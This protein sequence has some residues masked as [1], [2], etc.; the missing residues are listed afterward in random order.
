MA[1][2]TWKPIKSVRVG[3]KVICFDPKTMKPSVTTVIH[4]YVKPAQKPVYKIITSSGRSVIA[5]QDHKFRTNQGWQEVREFTKN[6]LVGIYATPVEVSRD[7][8]EKRTIM[9]TTG[10]AGVDERIRSYGL[11]PLMSDSWQVPIIARLMGFM[12][13][14]GTNVSKVDAFDKHMMDEDARLLGFTEHGVDDSG[15][16]IMLA[17]LGASTRMKIPDWMYIVSPHAKQE[18]IAGFLGAGGNIEFI[19]EGI[20]QSVGVTL[21]DMHVRYNN[22]LQM[23]KVIEQEYKKHLAAAKAWE[24]ETVY[25]EAQWRSLVTVEGNSVFVPIGQVMHVRNC[26]ISDITVE[27]ENHSFIGGAGFTVSNSAMGKQAVGI[28][29]SNF[30]NRID[31]MA[32]VLNYPQKPL[33]R[34]KLSKYT[35]GDHLPS[36][37]NA[38]VAIMTHTG[39][40]QEDSVMINKS[41]LDRGLFT[42]TYYKSYRDQCSKNHSTGEE[43]IFTKPDPNTTAHMK[44]Y[45]YSKLGDDGLVPVNT[46]VD[47][48]DVLI[49]KV[50]PH[51]IQG[52]IHPR[53]TSHMMK[54]NDEGH[55]DMNYIGTNA[56]GYKFAKVRIRKYRKPMIGDKCASRMAQKGTIGMVYNHQD[57]PFAKTGIVPD[58]IMNPHAIPSRMTIGQLMECIMG[59]ACCHIGS[60]G[61]ST[62]FND[63]TVEGIASVLEKSGM[64]R[65]GNEI[66]YNG[67]TGEMIQTEIF[68]GP[69][70]YQRL[71]HMVADKQHCLTEDHDVLTS[72]GWKPIAEVTMYDQVATLH[73]DKLVYEHPKAVLSFP[74]FSGKMYHIKNQAVDLNVT[75][76]H[77]MYISTC[78]TRKREWSDYRLVPA[79][80]IVGK[81]VRYK[82]NAVW[83]AP[84]YQFILPASG[85]GYREH[86]RAAKIVDMDAWLT[87]FGIWMAEGWTTTYE[88]NDGYDTKRVQICICKER[89]RDALFPALEKLGYTYN[90]HDDKCTI[91]ECQ[92]Y[93]YMKDLSVGAPQ[94]QLPDWV[95]SL[96][97]NQCRKLI[98]AMQLGDGSFSKT[99]TVYYTSS[100][101][102]A[103]QFMQLCL[104]AGW[105]GNKHLHHAKGNR[106]T[107]KDGRVIES[108]HDLWKVTVVVQRLNPTVNHTHSHKQNIQSEEVYDFT[109]PV[110]CLQVSSEV[111]MVRR[112]GKAVWTGNSRG[113]NGPVVLMTR[114]PAEGRAR[115]GGLRFGEMERDAIVAHGASAFLKERMQ[116]TSDNYRVFICRQCGLICTANPEKKIYKC[117]N[118]KNSADIT[119]VRIPYS[120]K[121]LIQELMTMSVAPRMIV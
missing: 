107:L 24:W 80:E 60:L 62:P 98:Y 82:K 35:H 65:Y 85:E 92:L 55:V 96:S 78:H 56:D 17:A 13:V 67:R 14:Q 36:G 26:M 54:A 49:G 72:D 2:G 100:E 114:Q 38:I 90:L 12:K 121:L 86:P 61:D 68:I 50:M 103:D 7:V 11:L 28:Y 115:N 20:F 58:L 41:A 111:F 46:H 39:F 76:N 53:D 27:S 25:T 112:N 40:N 48:N 71:K 19:D 22:K 23:G 45:N 94:K 42:S 31:T 104:H 99:S 81:E 119:Q 120:M 37:I 64:E 73:G 57:M 88:K 15:L 89:V 52:A 5:T 106:A 93:A 117:T 51:K 118:C 97:Q 30:N 33:V 83:D 109:G 6:T 105:S 8:A 47:G 110:Y 9:E 77:R 66:L 63:C 113:S 32:H 91:N 79:E 70:Y 10:V 16:H 102:L 101:K 95:W 4:Q 74:D 87:F 59:K 44:P 84:D 1:D 18:Y 43:E 21:D 34:T 69:T 3:D 116:D 75:L 29:M 108:H